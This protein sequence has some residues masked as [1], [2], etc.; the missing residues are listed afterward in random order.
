MMSTRIK[1]RFDT[2]RKSQEKGFV[3]YICAGDPSLQDTVD[4]ALSLEGAGI[5]VLELGVPFSDPLADG[6]V[7]QEASARALQN[8]ASLKG[9]LGAV[10]GIRK[11]S[12]IPIVLFSYLNPFYAYGTDSIARDSAGAGVDGVLLL[13]LPVEESKEMVGSLQS[14]GLDH[15]CLIAP[16]STDERVAKSVQNGS[17]FIYCVS[18]EGVTGVQEKSYTP[19]GLIQRARNHSSLP[20][21]LGFGVSNPQQA[22]TAAAHADAVVVGSA[23]V[24]QYHHSGSGKKGRAE[25]ASWVKTLVNSVKG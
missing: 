3:A 25:A 15:I 4:V 13:D 5:D 24:K 2:L 7:N 9:V 10:E 23:I 14:H 1:T 22:Q 20:I 12:E 16:T 8:G 19:R 21:A 6:K 18:R 17:G 11:K